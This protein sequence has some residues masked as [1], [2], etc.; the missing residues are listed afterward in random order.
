MNPVIS[1]A[2]AMGSVAISPM[3]DETD[4]ARFEVRVAGA[5]D[6]FLAIFAVPIMAPVIAAGISNRL[7]TLDPKYDPAIP[8]TP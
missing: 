8:A 1:P 3:S 2:A 6:G 7:P 5:S 4:V